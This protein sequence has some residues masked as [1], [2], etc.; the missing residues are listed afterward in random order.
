MEERD[1][2][3]WATGLSFICPL[4][5][6]EEFLAK[7]TLEQGQVAMPGLREIIVRIHGIVL[8]HAT[9]EMPLEKV[10]DH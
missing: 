8:A 7:Q 4:G 1:V 5:L 10:L 2:R 6:N 3:V 9:C